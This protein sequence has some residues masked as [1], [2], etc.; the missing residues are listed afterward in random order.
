M[1]LMQL[2][3][4]QWSRQVSRT[5]PLWPV[6]I[7]ENI[8]TVSIGNVFVLYIFVVNA[9]SHILQILLAYERLS[10]LYGYHVHS[11]PLDARTP[12]YRVIYLPR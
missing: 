3:T 2:T 11:G 1:I 10:L 12:T 4:F 7:D 8:V 6:A 9:R 5:T